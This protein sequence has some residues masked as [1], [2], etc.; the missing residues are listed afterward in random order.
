MLTFIM[1]T[2]ISPGSLHAPHTLEDLEKRVKDRIHDECEDIEWVQN[3]AVLGPY[4]YLDVFRAPDLENA[5]KVA[6]IVRSFGHA[7]TEL[8]PATDWSQFKELIR[9][10][11]ASEPGQA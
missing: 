9:G 7:H 2:R 8:W 11:E 4:D 6:T 1:L 3:Y 5:L 10:I